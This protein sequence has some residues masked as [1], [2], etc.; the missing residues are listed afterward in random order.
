MNDAMQV[1]AIV[2]AAGMGTRLGAAMPK[3][4]VELAGEPLLVHALRGLREAGVRQIV[5]TAPDQEAAKA[6]F[7]KAL[8]TA[9]IADV[10]LISGGRTRQ[11]SVAKGIAA[12]T[13]HF[14]HTTHIL[15]HD[16]ARALTPASVVM[17][18]IGLLAAGFP[19]VIPVLP[20]ADTIKEV[21]ID[22]DVQ[23]AAE[24]VGGKA[25]L[26]YTE[27]VVRTAERAA[28]RAVQTPQG[29]DLAVLQAA[30]EAGV[31]L[32]HDE[33]AGAPDDAAL[34]ELSG[35]VVHTVP[36]DARAMKITTP[37]DLRVAQ[38]LIADVDS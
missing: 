26:A 37:F 24:L 10:V 19:A 1:T 31:Q 18:V 9:E 14:P 34:V 23:A 27:K 5:V 22:A 36:G 16:A 30:H 12:A 25:E 20:V 2:A 4:L 3:A 7:S 28:L 6:E 21:E 15:V 17:R 33:Q 35:A 29:F 11:E 32:S 38:M 8:A 13:T